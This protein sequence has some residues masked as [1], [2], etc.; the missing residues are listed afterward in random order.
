VLLDALPL[1][2]NGKI[3]HRALPTPHDPRFNVETEFVAPRTPIEEALSGIWSEAMDIEQISVHDD[4]FELGGH[5]LMATKVVSRI[6]EAFQIE[7][8]LR[9]IFEAPTVAKLAA[10]LMQDTSQQERLEK[11]A[12][13][14]V[15]LSQLS[16]DEVED[17][18]N[19]R[20]TP[21]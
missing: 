19:E 9:Y 8:P 10:R 2:A 17:F 4:F 12:Q 11:I 13:A 6:R 1:T 3:D 5:S 21:A 15:E 18:F 20:T 14:L 7:L 16:E